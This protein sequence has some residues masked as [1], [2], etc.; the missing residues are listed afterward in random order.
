MGHTMKG[1]LKILNIKDEDG[2]LKSIRW[3]RLML[4]VFTIWTAAAVLIGLR[5]NFYELLNGVEVP[6]LHIFLY[7]YNS[8]LLWVLLTPVI[9][10]FTYKILFLPIKWYYSFLFHL[11]IALVISISQTLLFLVV[12]FAIQNQ[13]NLWTRN[14]TLNEYISSFFW[15]LLISS[16]LTYG[17]VVGILTA[18]ILNLRNKV[19]AK[20]QAK[21]EESLMQSKIQN[22]KYQLQPH[23]LFNSMQSISN[24]MH[25]D[26][27]LADK[28]IMSLSDILRFS[29]QQLNT[30][31]ITI[32]EEMDI[33]AKYL[34]FQKIRFDEKIK[35][36][37]TL[38]NEIGHYKTP[39][40]L[41]QTLVENSIKH[42]FQKT[43]KPVNIEIVV[44][45]KMDRIIFM[46][47]DDG[48]GFSEDLNSDFDGTGINNLKKRL[49]YFYGENYSLKKGVAS[50]GSE[51]IIDIPRMD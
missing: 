26:V 50:V 49:S 5:Y 20:K 6:W 51:I 38:D 43:G 46:I 12:D 32:K 24:L 14:G 22:L 48:S 7:N 37:L 29:I 2:I 47:R 42:G 34:E 9:L 30:D 27:E 31:Y 15:E 3:S 17:I 44:Q 19:V 4:A 35:Y 36:T 41:L 23:F 45:G 40:L 16:F 25:K 8:A 39:A 18:Y 28:A 33:T 1:M 13:L 21:V 11:G 10:V